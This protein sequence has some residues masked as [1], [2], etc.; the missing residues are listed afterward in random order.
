MSSD[1]RFS[2]ELRAKKFNSPRAARDGLGL[3]LTTVPLT[4]L[5]TTVM[6][7][8][9]WR[10]MIAAA[11]R[12]GDLWTRDAAWARDSATS[13]HDF[14]IDNCCTGAAGCEAISCLFQMWEMHG[15]ECTNEA[16]VK[17]ILQYDR[18]A[19][20]QAKLKDLLEQGAAGRTYGTFSNTFT[21]GP[22]GTASEIARMANGNFAATL[23][24]RI[25]NN[26]AFWAFFC[27]EVM[28]LVAVCQW[29][30]NIRWSLVRANP[31]L[32]ANERAYLQKY[33]ELAG[34][35]VR[36]A[37]PQ[38][39]ERFPGIN[40]TDF[41]NWSVAMNSDRPPWRYPLNRN[42]ENV[43]ETW[44]TNEACQ[45]DNPWPW[46]TPVGMGSVF[47]QIATPSL[48]RLSDNATRF[49]QSG[50]A[51]PI[52]Q[53]GEH[54]PLPGHYVADAEG[55]PGYRQLGIQAQKVPTSRADFAP[56]LDMEVGNTLGNGPGWPYSTDPSNNWLQ[57]QFVWPRGIV[58]LTPGQQYTP[59]DLLKLWFET[60]APL[61][62]DPSA[63]Y[64]HPNTRR[65]TDLIQYYSWGVRP[66][67]MGGGLG[68][69]WKRQFPSP[70]AQVLYCVALAQDMANHT[71]GEFISLGMA[72]WQEA[73]ETLPD[74]YRAISP[75][76]AQAM[77]RAMTQQN[78]D[79]VA[80]VY[81]AV[82]GTIT[83]VVTAIFPIA[84]VIL[85]V[86]FALVGLLIRFAQEAC[87][88]RSVS[89]PCI[90]SPFVRY[91]PG[92]PGE[93]AMAG[94]VCDFDTTGAGG[95][96]AIQVTTQIIQGAAARG[97]GAAEIAAAL[98]DSDTGV[99]GHGETPDEQDASSG[100]TTMMIGVAAAVA[101]SALLLVAASK[102]KK[103]AQEAI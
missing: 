70:V 13:F 90:A 68:R 80:G 15:V 93:A 49:G 62:Y 89:P 58:R 20:A 97:M 63:D 96:A 21:Y 4:L 87:I 81:A 55:Q 11:L 103:A 1:Y 54:L 10:S 2:S 31:T 102:K 75:A 26:A 23:N 47:D 38:T 59:Y 85:G 28:A 25:K 98:N 50:S 14:R 7:T 22:A 100:N 88:E 9:E 91:I 73:Y 79:A 95:A 5:R 45:Y 57:S 52:C 69:Q 44:K 82:T 94:P 76:S 61:T 60:D 18:F 72:K 43:V 78:I 6:D 37:H 83:T 66:N 77:N 36:Q 33:Y 24:G 41:F 51:S 19:V 32:W 84:G 39:F 16:F 42:Q 30:L 71:P 48:F 35:A 67:P 17:Y 8:P 27:E 74:Q 40:D 65:Q 53:G 99:N 12:D 46:A 29:A 64:Y 3:L 34:P 86:V 101:V 92:R 56:L